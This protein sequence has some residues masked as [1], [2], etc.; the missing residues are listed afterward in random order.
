[1]MIVG[2]AYDFCREG[3]YM[4]SA[5]CVLIVKLKLLQAVHTPLHLS[6]LSSADR[7][8]V[9]WIPFH[10][11]FGTVA[12][13]GWKT[14]IRLESD[15]DADVCFIV[16]AEDIWQQHAEQCRCECTALLNSINDWECVG[17][18]ST[19]QYLSKH[20]TIELSYYCW[21]IWDGQTSLWSSKAFH[22]W[23]Y[24]VIYGYLYIGRSVNAI[25][26]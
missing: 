23:Q 20:A 2:S 26:T 11:G 15:A 22:R 6:V 4:I 9:H 12:S 8:A 3:S 25:Y 14:S 10:F 16:I 13:A 24:L 18:N 21:R 17:R 5:F 1:M 19:V 7:R